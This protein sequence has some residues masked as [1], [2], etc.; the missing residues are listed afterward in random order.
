MAVHPF[1]RPTTSAAW[2]AQRRP[3][4]VGVVAPLGRDAQLIVGRLRDG[5]VPAQP[6]ESLEALT[7]GLEAGH[8]GVGLVTSESVAEG[9]GL[10]R[11]AAWIQTQPVWSDV[12]VIVLAAPGHSVAESHWQLGQ[13]TARPTGTILE[14]PVHANVLVSA[15]RLALLVRQR[16]LESRDL[17]DQL[18]Q[19]NET[20][21]RRV[22]ERTTEV[23]RL[24]ADLTLAEHAERRRI[25]HL[26]HDD[27]QQRL[28]GLAVTL[29]LLGR[30]VDSADEVRTQSLIGQSQRT[31]GGATDLTRSLSHE[32][33]PPILNGERI[34]DLIDWATAHARDRY[35]LT[36]HATVDESLSVKQDDIRVLM[37]QVLSE[38]LFNVSKHAGSAEA[39]VTV[40]AAPRP[41]HVRLA[42]ED[43]G[44]GFD[45]CGLQGPRGLGLASVRERI[46]LVGGDL[47]IQSA[48]GAGTRV[49]VDVPVTVEASLAAP[50]ADA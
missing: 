3:L 24:A 47:S 39:W 27:L 35:G 5:G 45:P 6:V 9:L 11:L 42:V 48:P 17:L 14:R 30:A 50:A 23:R 8:L 22:D 40:Q 38:L 33:A 18:R 2:P 15:A 20:L 16:Q 4:A 34:T 46:E 43:H 28:H 1:R 36:L 31:L 37:W 25:A 41:G 44:H 12:P 10:R 21:E 7:D 49:T 29:A 13:I 32:L 26:L 19:A